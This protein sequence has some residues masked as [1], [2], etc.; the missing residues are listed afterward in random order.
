MR[1]TAR[2]HFSDRARTMLGAGGGT[3]AP[4]LVAVTAD[5]ASAGWTV[6]RIDQ[7]YRVAGR[8]VPAPA[9]RLDEAW[10]TVVAALRGRFRA[11][12]HR[13]AQQRRPGRLP[14]GDRV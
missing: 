8:R 1:P 7:P 6:A 10:I 13:R 9:P 14:Y 3:D 4:D 5:A 11:A 2:A 12:G